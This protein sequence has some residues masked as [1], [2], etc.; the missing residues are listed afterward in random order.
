MWRRV[1]TSALF[2]AVSLLVQACGFHPCTGPSTE[3]VSGLRS[4]SDPASVKAALS[5]CDWFANEESHLA[6][7]DRRPRFDVLKI[8]V[9][10]CPVVPE[11]TRVEL[12]FLNDRLTTVWLY[13]PET[14]AYMKRLSEQHGWR[15]DSDGSLF[16]APGTRVWSAVDWKKEPYVAWEDA[17]LAAEERDWIMTYASM[18]HA[19]RDDIRLEARAFRGPD[20]SAGPRGTMNGFP[21]APVA[22]LERASA[23]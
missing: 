6:L 2:A 18:R 17:C 13:M 5:S 21:H 7:D 10:N 12:N 16:K 15:W 14:R 22:Q 8:G 23:F 20:L 11:A 3:L 19:T 4:R 9:G 1:H